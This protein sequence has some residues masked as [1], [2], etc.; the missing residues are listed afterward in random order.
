MIIRLIALFAVTTTQLHALQE[1]TTE[2]VDISVNFSASLLGSATN[3][4]RITARD[5][6]ARHEYGGV[7]V[8]SDDETLAVLYAFENSKVEVP[9]DSRYTFLGPVGSELYILP[10]TLE[11]DMLYLGLSSEN[12]TSQTGWVGHGVEAGLLVRGFTTGTF[13]SNRVNLRLATFSG[14]GNFFLY[15]TN[16]FGDPTIFYNTANG[17]ALD[18][19]R[20]LSPGNH[21]HF[22]WAFTEAGEYTFGLIAS[23]TTTTG[24]TFTESELTEFTFNVIPE[25]SSAAALALSGLALLRRP[26]RSR[27][28]KKHTT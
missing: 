12:K 19:N 21:S 14:P 26:F 11:P 5:E 28:D 13:Q 22:N 4:W 27:N 6:D 3:P 16:A 8:S 15:S 23:A 9:N 25:P 2:H 7:R 17:L 20:Q 10:Q 24:G 1:L 18:D